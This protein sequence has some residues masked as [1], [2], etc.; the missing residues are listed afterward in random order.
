MERP[1]KETGTHEVPIKLYTDVTATLK[2]AVKSANEQPA[3][4][5]PAAV[6]P[7]RTTK[8]RRV[9]VR[10]Q[11]KDV[12][13]DTFNMPATSQVAPSGTEK[14]RQSTGVGEEGRTSGAN[15]SYSQGS[16]PD[17]H[18]ALP[19]SLEA[20]QGLLGS[21]LIAPADVMDDCAQR[22]KAEAFYHPAHQTIFA[23]LVELWDKQQPAD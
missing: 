8:E 3:P 23:L 21:M 16:S 20:E 12:N 4:A 1:I 2:V 9:Q 11:E 7:R 22:I 19:H 5:E 6:A 17:I 10:R 15:G 14:P 18:R 13:E